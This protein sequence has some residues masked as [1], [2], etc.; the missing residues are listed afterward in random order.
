MRSGRP[1]WPG[2]SQSRTHS[3]GCVRPAR[4]ARWSADALEIGTSRSRSSPTPGSNSICRAVPVSTTA[5]TPSTVTDVSATFVA[6]TTFRRA[7]FCKARS[8]TSGGRSPCS[9]S[10]SK[11]R[12][13]ASAFR[14]PAVSRISRRPGRNTSTSPGVASRTRSTTSAAASTADRS[15]P[16]RLVANFDWEGAALAGDDGA[17]AEVRRDRAGV[18]RGGHDHHFEFGPHRLSQQADH[19]EGEVGVDA[20]LV[21]LV[22]HDG[23]DALQERVV[24]QQPQQD[25][26]GDGE[27]AGVRPGLAVEADVVAEGAAEGRPVFRRHPPRRRPRGEASRLQHEHEPGLNGEEGGRHAGGLAGPGRGAQHDGPRLAQCGEQGG[28][29]G[30]DGKGNAC[31]ERIESYPWLAATRRLCAGGARGR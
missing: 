3:P 15:R 31:H 14:Q 20:A 28:Q 7:S 21:E 10:T 24:V 29:D 18:H 4:P 2:S 13:S 23:G 30:I 19:A 27:A 16:A 26:G 22:E 9:G 11:P 5:V 8:C 12:A 17:V 6:S 1:R 25:A